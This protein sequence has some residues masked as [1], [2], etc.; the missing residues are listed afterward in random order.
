[1]R[2]K[3]DCLEGECFFAYLSPVGWP[4]IYSIC[5]S[6]FDGSKDSFPFDGVSSAFI[7]IGL[8]KG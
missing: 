6:Q 3:I 1:M 2:E 4:D 7:I 8:I 5:F